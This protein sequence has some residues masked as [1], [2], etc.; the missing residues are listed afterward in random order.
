MNGLGVILLPIQHMRVN[1][2]TKLRE[3]KKRKINSAVMSLAG[4]GKRN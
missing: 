4:A 1:I 2:Q 3:G